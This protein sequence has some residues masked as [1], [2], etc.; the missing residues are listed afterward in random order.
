MWLLFLCCSNK[1]NIRFGEFLNSINIQGIPDN[2]E[3]RSCYCFSDQGNWIGFGLPE[4]NDTC[5]WGGFTGPFLMG[6]GKWIGPSLLNV[7]V[8]DDERKGINII[9]YADSADINYIPG[10]LSQRYRIKAYEINCD[11]IFISN[12]TAVMRI[13]F[14]NTGKGKA[15]LK[16]S[17]RGEVFP[18]NSLT[19]QS[20]SVIWR[21]PEDSSVLLLQVPESYQVEAG[22]SSEKYYRLRLKTPIVVNTG[23]DKY[24]YI[25]CSLVFNQQEMSNEQS[26]IKKFMKSPHTFFRENE[27]RWGNYIRGVTGHLGKID[28]S[29][30][31][32]AVKSVLTLMTN[33]RSKA[34]DLQYD[35]LFPSYNPGYFNGFWAWD[36]WK[37]AAALSSFAPELAKDQIR[38]MFAYQNDEGMI[39]DVIYKDKTDN[40]WC[41][42]KPPLAAWAVWRVY[43]KTGDFNFI[44]EMLPK[45]V[46]YHTWWYDF[47]DHD[48][49]GLCE[50][51]STDG[52]LVA[53]K[54]ESGMD[55]GVRFD[56]SEVVK[57]NEGNWSLTQ[58]SVDLNSYLYAEKMIIARF[59]EIL[60]DHFQSELWYQQATELR[61]KIRELMFDEESGFFYDITLKDKSLIKVQGSEGWIPLWAGVATQKQADRVMQVMIDSSKFA[62]FI[63]LPTVSADNPNFMSGY[64]RGPVWLDQV[65]F[66]ITGLELYGY[67]EQADTF[68]DLI[69]QRLKGLKN[70]SLPIYE[71]YDP[72]NGK[73]LKAVHFSWSAAHLLLLLWGEY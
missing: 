36:S 52:S 25:F 59:L 50:Y 19:L 41:N 16:L 22:S 37:H 66:G 43:K 39:P 62:T 72:R 31:E 68:R 73:G 69:F 7:R 65:Y 8:E 13:G 46:K 56:N 14:L 61:D 24:R 23:E 26:I 21:I 49:N 5:Y 55:D 29:Y 40:N 42:T 15:V 35:G 45:L 12:R 18:G 4:K 38:T 28:T 17:W 64:W 10:R 47:R 3:D 11:L 60:G 2:A 70:S 51:G 57:N 58:E 34:G 6:Q 9:P 27:K 54:W 33:W 53:A 20:N 48:S 1:E 71:N 32:I 30:K 44:E 63:P 67:S